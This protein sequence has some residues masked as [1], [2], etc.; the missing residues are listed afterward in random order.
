MDLQKGFTAVLHV[1]VG[2]SRVSVRKDSA[3]P[4][5]IHIAAPTPCPV[6]EDGDDTQLVEDLRG[7]SRGTVGGNRITIDL[8]S[9]PGGPGN[10]TGS[11]GIDEIVV[12]LRARVVDGDNIEV[13]TV[14]TSE[15]A[16]TA[17]DVT[18]ARYAGTPL[19]EGHSG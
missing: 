10:V 3:K 9:A 5:R 6:V 11:I 15:Q 4:T 2:V 7:R 19:P 17:I 1:L 13:L 14:G 8:A 18:V 12:H 16:D